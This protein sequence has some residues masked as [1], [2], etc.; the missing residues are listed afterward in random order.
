MNVLKVKQ[1]DGTIITIP[2]GKGADG[3]TPVKGKDYF[4]DEDKNEIITEVKAYTDAELEP[5][6][7]LLNNVHRKVLFNSSSIA[8]MRIQIGDLQGADNATL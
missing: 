4:T 3:H 5:T 2:L 1:P 7:T 6:K 8:E